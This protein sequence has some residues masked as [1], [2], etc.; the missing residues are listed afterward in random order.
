[1]CRATHHANHS[2]TQ[3]TNRSVTENAKV[4]HEGALD[5]T[6][7]SLDGRH[8]EAGGRQIVPVPVRPPRAMTS[9]P[10]DDLFLPSRRAVGG[11]NYH[12]RS[13]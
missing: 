4:T 8:R 12:D 5:T 7:K 6:R 1:V 13:R 9:L 10:Q 11:V 2:V 3:N